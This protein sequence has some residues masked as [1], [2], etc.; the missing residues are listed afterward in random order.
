MN[1]LLPLV[2]AGSMQP[3]RHMEA[4]SSTV[5]NLMHV[6]PLLCV[7]RSGYKMRESLKPKDLCSLTKK[8]FKGRKVQEN[9]QRVELFKT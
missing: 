5:D 8:A 7:F 6:V 3:E 1:S 4:I 2:G 9:V